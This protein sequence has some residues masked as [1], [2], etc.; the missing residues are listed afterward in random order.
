VLRVATFNVNG[1]RA[2]VR[3]GFAGWLAKRGPDVVCL[4]EVRASPQD[5]PAGAF[6]GYH[7]A[8]HEG[9]QRGRAGVAVLSRAEPVAVRIGFG[10]EEFDPQGRYI[11]V[12]LPGVTVG[13]LYLPKGEVLGEKW[14]G[15]LRFMTEFAAHAATAASRARRAGRG[16]VVCGDYN[17]AH[18]EADLKSWKANQ[19]SIGFLP[20]ERAWIGALISSGALVDVVRNLHPDQDGPYTWWSWRGRQFDNDVGWRIDHQLADP[21]LAAAAVTGGVDRE[22]SYAER[23]SDH[24]PVWVDYDI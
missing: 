19:R 13:S 7:L 6:D 10:S 18:T 16:L 22:N 5:I 1:I 2:A 20:A 11:E 14:D 24:A 9:G 17:I 21:A 3:R 12:D 15:K 23:I 4:Q 8:H